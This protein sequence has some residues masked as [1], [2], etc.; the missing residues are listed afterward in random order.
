MNTQTLNR[1]VKASYYAPNGVQLRK[2]CY[3]VMAVNSRRA[4][5]SE[6]MLI[7]QMSQLPEKEQEKISVQIIKEGLIES[8]KKDRQE[9][10][11]HGLRDIQNYLAVNNI[12][13]EDLAKRVMNPNPI[14]QEKLE[15]MINS[16]ED[17]IE[18]A[19]V[20]VKA[21]SYQ[22]ILS[23]LDVPI[24]KMQESIENENW[25]RTDV[26]V[27][28]FATMLDRL[29]KD[30]KNGKDRSLGTIILFL[31]ATKALAIGIVAFL[32][33]FFG[34]FLKWLSKKQGIILGYLVTAIPKLVSLILKGFGWT[35]DKASDLIKSS[36]SKFFSRQAKIAM[37]SPQFRNAYYNI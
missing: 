5:T 37:Q 6:Y 17:A 18:V 12:S 8:C 1:M 31:I 10:A 3:G 29:L 30:K 22:E 16:K 25:L 4:S 15:G 24:Q 28:S 33:Y 19:S 35:L 21:R 9:L 26:L 23:F 11:P 7:E 32:E 13:S 36:W 14:Y 2:A 27:A 20:I 34:D